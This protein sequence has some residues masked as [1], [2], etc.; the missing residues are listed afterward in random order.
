MIEW[1]TDVNKVARQ[2]F[3]AAADMV[4]VVYAILAEIDKESNCSVSLHTVT[5]IYGGGMRET[6]KKMVATVKDDYKKKVVRVRFH[7]QESA[8][9]NPNLSCYTEQ[10][11]AK[12]L[13]RTDQMDSIRMFAAIDDEKEYTSHTPSELKQIILKKFG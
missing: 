2:K 9:S 12:G 13:R 8:L 6:I 5:Y 3:D 4:K 11:K 7:I 10:E 1:P